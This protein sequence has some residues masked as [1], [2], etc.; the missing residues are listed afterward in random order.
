MKKIRCLIIALACIGLLTADVLAQTNAQAKFDKL[1]PGQ[2]DLKQ[3]EK[4]FGETKSKERIID[5][6]GKYSNSG[7]FEASVNSRNYEANED[8]TAGLVKRTLY[9]LEYEKL[10]FTLRVFDNPWQLYSVETTNS[11]ITIKDTKI[12]DPL[13]KIES[14]FGKPSW[15]T[16]ASTELWS[17]VYRK[18][19][20]EFKFERDKNSPKFPMKLV[21]K[22][23]VVSI[24]LSDSKVSFVSY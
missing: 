9:K 17:A 24:K 7:E 1:I 20:L 13:T 2:T 5:W 10:G 19:G 18:Q 8:S 21:E 12:G 14:V 3:I 15:Q 4:I 6:W 23:V 16:V 22:P 11:D